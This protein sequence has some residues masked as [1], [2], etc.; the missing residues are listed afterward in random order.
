MICYEMIAAGQTG[1]TGPAE[2]PILSSPKRERWRRTPPRNAVSDRQPSTRSPLAPFSSPANLACTAW[3]DWTEPPIVVWSIIPAQGWL[4]ETPLGGTSRQLQRTG[5][6]VDIA[7]A[8]GSPPGPTAAFGQDALSRPWPL[9]DPSAGVIDQARET[10]PPT[11]Q[12]AEAALHSRLNAAVI[13]HL[14]LGVTAAGLAATLGTTF[15]SWAFLALALTIELGYFFACE[16]TSGQTLGKRICGVRVIGLDGRPPA[17]RAIAIRNAARLLDALPAYHASGLLTMM[18]AGRRRRQR[19]GDYL[20]HTTVIAAPGGRALAPHR[21]WLLP[22]LTAL[23]TIIST[24]VIIRAIHAAHSAD[25]VRIEFIAG[26][27]HA[28]GTPAPCQCLYASLTA[29]G[30]TTAAAWQTLEREIALAEYT[31]DPHQLPADFTAAAR[32]CTQP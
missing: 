25:R 15:R 12:A 6:Q 27:E 20:A 7:P 3:G 10:A 28:G 31:H 11:R 19:I 8:L 4:R 13:D 26:C 29:R 5:E 21:R 18:G 14:L 22:L 23:A 1:Q 32:A 9:L 24:A 2:S 30:Y 16:L 17:A